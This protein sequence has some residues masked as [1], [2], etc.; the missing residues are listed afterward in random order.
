VAVAV[1]LNLELVDQAV[2]VVQV[3]AVLVQH[4]AQVLELL[5]PLIL[6]VVEVVAL[7]IQVKVEMVVQVL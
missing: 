1:L 7:F 3:V 5:E 4:Q 6:V 2:L